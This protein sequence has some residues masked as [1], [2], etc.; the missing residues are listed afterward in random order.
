MYLVQRCASLLPATLLAFAAML[1]RLTQLINYGDLRPAPAAHLR[2]FYMHTFVCMCSGV[3]VV[4]S[5]SCHSARVF[6]GPRKRTVAPR[7]SAGPRLNWLFWCG[8]GVVAC[9]PTR[10]EAT[11]VSVSNVTPF[12]NRTQLSSG[13]L[14]LP[15]ACDR[16]DTACA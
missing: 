15:F 7:P 11:P 12:S 10:L 13:E 1:L 3:L 6:N 2:A 8:V 14:L 16:M 9:N 5:S 4:C